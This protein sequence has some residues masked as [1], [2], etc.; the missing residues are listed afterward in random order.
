[1]SSKIEWCDETWNPITGCSKIS[2]GCANCYA[3]RM[4]KRLGGRF[5]YPK[6][7]PFACTSH[8]ARL[9]D[10]LKWKKPRRIFVCSMGDLFHEDVMDM[11]PEWIDE[12]FSVIARCPQHKFLLLTKRIKNMAKYI[13]WLMGHNGPDVDRI[14]RM[15]HYER[16]HKHHMNYRMGI[17]MSNVWLG[18]TAENQS[19]ADERIPGLLNIPAAGHFVFVEPMLGPVDIWQSCVIGASD[20]QRAHKTS[21]VQATRLDWVICGAETGQGKREMDLKWAADLLLECQAHNVPFF[22]KKFS[23][24]SQML[25]REFPAGLTPAGAG[26]EEK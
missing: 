15:P 1:M 22:G 2:E 21:F 17:P 19:T 9:Y 12:V 13:G 16:F 5:G 25:P 24:G 3:E 26:K 23:D 20:R 14:M 4:S 6:E 18:V 7:Q 11:A 10:P 8:E